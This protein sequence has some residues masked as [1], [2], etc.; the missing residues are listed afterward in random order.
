MATRNTSRKRAN[1][2]EG[3]DRNSNP[4][5]YS[6]DGVGNSGSAQIGAQKEIGF[7]AKRNLFVDDGWVDGTGHGENPSVSFPDSTIETADRALLLWSRGALKGDEKNLQ[8]VRVLFATGERW[9]LLKNEQKFVTQDGVPILPLVAIIRKQI[10]VG[11]EVSRKTY[12]STD[13][14]QL[15]F[16]EEVNIDGRKA[17]RYTEIA[18]PIPFE[19]SYSMEFW[20]RTPS[21]LNEIIV[22]FLETMRNRQSMEVRVA[23]PVTGWTFDVKFE[24]SFTIGENLDDFTGAQRIVKTSVDA[25][26]WGRHLRSKTARTRTYSSITSVNFDV[27]VFDED[28]LS[29]LATSETLNQRRTGDAPQAPTRASSPLPHAQPQSIFERRFKGVVEPVKGNLQQHYQERRTTQ[30]IDKGRKGERIYKINEP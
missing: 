1:K 8:N 12:N 20:C 30:L 23:D 11:N 19:I 15:S 17:I 18:P 21:E 26:L 3:V 14:M 13:R 16:R 29:D 9:A 24:G 22:Q 27:E 25:T 5:S 4:H 10:L 28:P 2:D 7:P 6:A